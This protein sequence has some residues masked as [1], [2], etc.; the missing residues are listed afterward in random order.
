LQKPPG[1]IRLSSDKDFRIPK[2]SLRTQSSSIKGGFNLKTRNS[3]KSK[4]AQHARKRFCK[5]TGYNAPIDLVLN[6]LRTLEEWTE[7]L[8]EE[9]ERIEGL[10]SSQFLDTD[11]WQN[12][13]AIRSMQTLKLRPQ[14][15]GSS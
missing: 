13:S 7:V 2:P 15:K 10:R 12:S 14:Q 9:R 3:K 6:G 4:Y 11:S 8:S 5:G 1:N